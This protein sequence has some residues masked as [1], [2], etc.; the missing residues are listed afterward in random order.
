MKVYSP[1]ECAAC[2]FRTAADYPSKKSLLQITERCNLH[3]KHCFVSSVCNGS[4]MELD[5]ILNK[6]IPDFVKNNISKVTLTGG[7]PFLYPHLIEVVEAFRNNEMSV[8]ICT[9]A[10][11]VTPDFINRIKEF[12]GV[13]F[14]V[15][16]DGFSNY[17][18]GKFRGNDS[19]ELFNHIL[20]NIKLLGSANMLNGIL[21]TPNIYASIEEYKEI[22]Q[23]AKNN[24][25]KYVLFNPLSEFG[26]GE[27]S[28]SLSYTENQMIELRKAVEVYSDNEFE[29]VFIRFPNSNSMPLNKCPAGDII[30]I[31]TNGDI[32]YCPYMV[33]AAK[34]NSS[35]Y[36]YH[37]FVMGNIFSSNFDWKRD[38]GD[39]CF[40]IMFDQVCAECPKRECKKGCYASKIAMGKHLEE[41]D[42]QMCPLMNNI[43]D[44]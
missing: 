21:V 24:G 42:E 38:V 33:F 30:Y 17:S 22:C 26:R 16:L 8:C 12:G 32:A 7:E 19:A 40:P 44:N 3:C 14:N 36:D 11:L 43:R 37:D 20:N 29:T 18:H 28:V 9:N 13:H 4:D 15:S 39:Y 10:S 23:F 25:A 34:N 5:L 1:S 27:K 6:I 31:F 41:C 35:K 2:Y